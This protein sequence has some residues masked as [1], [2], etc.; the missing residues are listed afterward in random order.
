MT[1]PTIET[2]SNFWGGGGT[3]KPGGTGQVSS[4]YGQRDLSVNQQRQ[5]DRRSGGNP[6]SIPT[7]SPT[8]GRPIAGGTQAPTLQQGTAIDPFS[9][10]SGNSPY[11][12]YAQQVA[13][14]YNPS[15]LPRL[16]IPSMQ[17]WAR[18]G[19]QFQQQYMGYKQAQTGAI[20]EQSYWNIMRLAP[21]QGGTSLSYRR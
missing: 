10:F 21:P 20:P 12:N 9:Y 15:Q 6:T 18:M 5:A 2:I 1:Y 17:T 16:M 4:T 11:G 3:Y 19:P 13:A 7:I 8:G 14:G